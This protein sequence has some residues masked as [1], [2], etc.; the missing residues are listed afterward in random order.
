MRENSPGNARHDADGTTRSTDEATPD[1]SGRRRGLWQGHA[2]QKTIGSYM[3][4]Y[5]HFRGE[6]STDEMIITP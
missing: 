6:L 3:D 2:S 4:L 1:A 5:V